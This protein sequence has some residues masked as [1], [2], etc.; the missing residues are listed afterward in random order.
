M[1]PH[2]TV[3]PATTDATLATIFGALH[4]DPEHTPAQHQTLHQAGVALIAALHPRDPTE[5]SYTA[6]AAAA[7][8]GSMECFRRAMLADAPDNVALR[9]HGKAEALS[10]INKDMV[11]TL[12]D[13]QA[14]APPAQR[15]PQPAPR[16]ATPPRPNAP[17]AARPAATTPPKPTGMH[18]PMPSERPSPAPAAST[19]RPATPAQPTP[20]P[21]TRPAAIPPRLTPRYDFLFG[22]QKTPRPPSPPLGPNLPPPSGQNPLA[23]KTPCPVSSCRT[24]PPP[25]AS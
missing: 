21:V 5:A 11:R 13:C 2:L 20:T 1:T 3:D 19:P 18:D 9:W 8:F 17:E 24:R 12:K 6:R 25:T 10:R 7:Y 4:R 22:R 23:D 14:E 16:P 15:Q